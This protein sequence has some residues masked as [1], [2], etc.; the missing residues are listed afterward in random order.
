MKRLLA[1]LLLSTLLLVGCGCQ[2]NIEDT[3]ELVPTKPIETP[4]PETV[5][6]SVSPTP[7]P[8]IT[9]SVPITSNEITADDGIVIFRD[10]RQSMQLVMPDQ[11]VADMII[12]DFLTRID[13]A[14]AAASDLSS[15][16][17]TDYVASDMWTPYLNSV[18]YTPARI[19]QS[20]LSLY[21]STIQ[22]SGG[23]HAIYVSRAAN[24][25]TATGEVLTLGSILADEDAHGQLC[26]L[27][28]AQLNC[29]K[30][31]K[32]LRTDFADSV[33]QR[34]ASEASYDENW[35][36]SNQGICFYFDHYEIA[37]YSSGIITAEIPYKDLVGIIDD[38]FFPPESD[39]ANG[40]VTVTAAE[41]IDVT[42]FTRISEVVVDKE[43]PMY[44]IHCN[45]RVQNL[46][47]LMADAELGSNY[48]I[49]VAQ[50]LYSSDAIIVQADLSLFHRLEVAYESNEQTIIIP[51]LAE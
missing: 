43:S 38:A 15:Q 27:V 11:D 22:Y 49:F 30:E 23:A 17:Q 16:A 21:G 40:S 18:T 41:D 50:A 45:G 28:I 7:M 4:Q 34:F 51:F 44:I 35:Y 13:Q 14:S 25:N 36:F 5:D 6:S 8:M 46:R 12:I 48:T 3:P 26:E 10:V 31:E 29:I 9:V 2:T 19:D 42:Q 39:V 32:Y 37:P 1:I 33:Q 47:V 24:Y 20:V